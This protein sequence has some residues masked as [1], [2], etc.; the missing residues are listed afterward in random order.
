MEPYMSKKTKKTYMDSY[1][2]PYMISYMQ[3]EF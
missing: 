3:D 2:E 1:M